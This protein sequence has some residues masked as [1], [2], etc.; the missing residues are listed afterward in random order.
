MKD[1]A[2]V[3]ERIRNF[4]E[5]Q[6]AVQLAYIDAERR[7]AEVEELNAGLSDLV[8][9]LLPYSGDTCPGECRYRAECKLPSNQ[10]STGEPLTCVAY[11]HLLKKASELGAKVVDQ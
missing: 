8:A 10:S 2:S 7:V 3:D 5:A 6:V 11:D 9:E 1:T 4:S